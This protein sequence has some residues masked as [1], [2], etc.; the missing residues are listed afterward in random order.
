MKKLFMIIAMALT[1]ASMSYAQQD[2]QVRPHRQFDKTE[3][4]KM[5]T[6]R[7]AKELGLDEAQ[8]DSL[9]KLNTRYADLITPGRRPVMFKSRAKSDTTGVKPKHGLVVTQREDMQKYEE[10]VKAL[11]TPDQAK[12]YEEIKKNRMSNPR[13]HIGVPGQRPTFKNNQQDSNIVV[14]GEQE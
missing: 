12:K 1:T 7:T 10:Q 9:L 14:I 2:N 13:R 4:I 6:Q 3:M 8:T 11:L 5:R